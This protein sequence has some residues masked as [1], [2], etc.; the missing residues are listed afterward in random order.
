MHSQLE[1]Y[2]Y[3]NEGNKNKYKNVQVIA[4]TKNNFKIDADC[5]GHCARNDILSYLVAW[6]S[7]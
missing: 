3:S 1:V 5:T 7:K 6:N 2:N 4:S